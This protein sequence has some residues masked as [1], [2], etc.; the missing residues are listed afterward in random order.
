MS[1]LIAHAML[2]MMPAGHG[3]PG[4]A[5]A[6][7]VAFARRVRHEADALYYLGLL[8]GGVVFALTPLLTVYLPL[9]SLLLPRRLLDLHAQRIVAH[10]AYLVKQAVFLVRLNAGMVWG[11]HPECRA[12][13]ELAAYAEDPGS[14][15][16]QP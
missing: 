15:R 4:L 6:D 16:G 9:P 8:L 2:A 7:A 3:L 14:F 10:R 12:A 13:F 1:H 5:R 11:A